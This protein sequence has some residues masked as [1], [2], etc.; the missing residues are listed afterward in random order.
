MKVKF[1]ITRIILLIPVVLLLSGCASKRYTKKAVKF[2]Q[3][4]L[5]ED[6]ADY[7]Y[8]AV[9][10]KSSNLEAKLGLHKTG[11]I[12]LDNKLKE[13]SN[14]YKQADYEKVVYFYLDADAYA[15]KVKAVGVDLSFPDIYESY[16]DEAKNDYLNKLYADGLEKLNREEF[17][18]AEKIFGEIR[19]VDPGFK[20]ISEKYRIA[21]IEPVYREANDFFENGMY[22]KAYYAYDRVLSEAGNYK[23]ALS[24]KNESREK[25]TISLIVTR[26]GFTFKDYGQTSALLTSAVKSRLLKLD[27]PFLKVI[28]ESSLPESIYENGRIDMAS[29]RIAGINAIVSGKV[30][31]VKKMEGKLT[32]ETKRGYLKE[33]RKT[34]NSEGVETTTVD[35][36][37]TE[38]LQ[39]H[40]E[41]FAEIQVDYSMISTQNGE[42][43]V[44][45]LYK[46][47]NADMANYARFEGDKNKLVPGYW[48][49][50][51]FNSD[52]DVVKDN[53]SDISALRSLLNAGGKI[54]PVS[55]LLDELVNQ[56]ASDI[57]NKIDSF[58]PE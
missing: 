24:L 56:A 1:L 50:S 15:N 48:K 37:K 28:D 44:S 13:V 8:E 55:V 14:A 25:A 16:Y 39:F 21:R 51:L 23:Q 34:T 46:Q 49:N 41:N 40:A 36:K 47:R 10:R 26:F 6:A 43:M 54:K 30:I 58:N 9:K 22:R 57:V 27:N 11:Q 4:G 2:E 29:A 12:K 5:Y 42:V 52:Q 32:R 3:A 7:Y 20:D 18:A 38:Y 35:Y 45:N 53:P 33:V 19:K 31:N 17:G